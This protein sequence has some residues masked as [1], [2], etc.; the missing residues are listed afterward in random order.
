MFI[1]TRAMNLPGVTLGE[2]AVVAAGS[3]VTKCVPA[4]SIVAGVPA[5][6]IGA[7]N[8]ALDYSVSYVRPFF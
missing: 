8:K 3:V 1:G 6:P 7:R 4:F 2:G 5:I